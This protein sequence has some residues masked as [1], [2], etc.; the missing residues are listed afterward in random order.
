MNMTL[1]VI[2]N[3]AGVS[4]STVS[5]VLNGKPG[6]STKTIKKVEKVIREVDY[7]PKPISSRQ[8]V[9]KQVGDAG[10]NKTIAF[11][12]LE[13]SN[14]MH[15]TSFTKLISG[16]SRAL[17]D[18][19]LN[20]VF[21]QVH[22]DGQLP[23]IIKDGRVDGLLLTGSL[24]N[25]KIVSKLLKFPSIWLS[26]SVTYSG[27]VVLVGNDDVGFLA[28]DFLA[29]KKYDNLICLNPLTA[30]SVYKN[31][32]DAFAYRAKQ[33]GYENVIKL[34]SSDEERRL[35]NEIGLKGLSEV[36][37]SL[38]EELSVVKRQRLG[39]FIPDDMITAASYPVFTNYGFK[40]GEDIDIVSCGNEDAYLLGLTPTPATIDLNVEFQGYRAVEQLLWRIKNPNDRL[41]L[42]SRVTPEIKERS[43]WNL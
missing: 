34:E 24:P 3:M 43:F 32:C 14:Y 4:K 15:G 1:D 29:E 11:V 13:S 5:R 20:M 37:S 23:P 38:V 25:P 27:D 21:V 19:G 33:N 8:G 41:K 26:S 16:V 18:N 17:S 10:R 30:Y 31:R 39:V 35:I 22:G 12:Q 7:I 28:A 2:A 9:R 40:I 36:I 42:H 6:L